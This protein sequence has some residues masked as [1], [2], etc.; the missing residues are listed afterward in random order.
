MKSG[1]NFM[2]NGIEYLFLSNLAYCNF[3]K[4]DIGSSLNSL[5]FGKHN[6][7]N[8][9]RILGN[10]N[11][12]VN[13]DNFELSYSFFKDCF[14]QWKVLNIEDQTACGSEPS[15]YSSGFFAI[16][17]T[18]KH[19][20][21]ISYRG[22]ETIS[23]EDAYKDFIENDLLLS[24]GKRP[25]QFD[26]GYKFYKKLI[27]D[28]CNPN[29]VRLTGHSLGGG[30]AQ[31]VAVMSQKDCLPIPNT[32]TW[33]SVGI[34]KDGLIRIE[35]FINFES[36]LKEKI[37]L[38]IKNS[39]YLS[40]LKTNYFNLLSKHIDKK[41]K[42]GNLNNCSSETLNFKFQLNKSE[43][44][45]F[46]TLLSA[47]NFYK[48]FE[49][50]NTSSADL[51]AKLKEIFLNEKMVSDAVTQSEKI[52]SDFKENKIY[53]N[54]VLNFV[55][56]KD[57]T[58]SLFK[59]AGSVYIVDQNFSRQEKTN[60][61]FFKN[62][63]LFSKSFKNYHF[64]DVFLPFISTSETQMGKLTKKINDDYVS[65]CIRK[66]IRM[67]EYC[68][69]ELL[70]LYYSLERITEDNFEKIKSLLLG[71]LARIKEEIK[72]KKQVI[73]RIKNSNFLTLEHLW[74]K[75][76]LKLSTPYQYKDIY[77]YLVFE[78]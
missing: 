3:N 45:D 8:R 57:L 18:K 27:D 55:H 26:E 9:K 15:K 4:N 13:A 66:L 10:K 68:D 71:G 41:K 11:N 34:Q 38:H 47:E 30:I 35:D 69:L 75:S 67:E 1:A 16:A 70:V 64:S 17:F 65:S 24:F 49:Y 52:L 74:L 7:E 40:K 53:E 31:Y 21:V 20:V 29:S 76:L 25:P 5:L 78:I 48:V 62:F 54:I 59:H 44:M 72:F 14:E 51:E 32:C 6:E 36:L 33:N 23:L 12:L 73:N 61:K 39:E 2:I 22:S 42:F 28:G 63:S 56:S 58:V 60:N 43:K 46:E 37:G 19:E 77:D 50:S